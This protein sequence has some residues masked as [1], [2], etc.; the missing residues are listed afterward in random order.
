MQSSDWAQE[1]LSEQQQKYAAQDVIYLHELYD[2]LKSMLDREKR[3]EIAFKCF[4]ALEARV[5]LDL[6]GWSNDDIFSH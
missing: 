1:V 3:T 6:N 4:E 5:L 2:K